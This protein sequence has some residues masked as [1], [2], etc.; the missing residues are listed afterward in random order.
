MFNALITGFIK[1]LFEFIDGELDIAVHY[2]KERLNET[3]T[4]EK[5]VEKET[6]NI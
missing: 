1:V 4:T 3:G 5:D 6:V 2:L